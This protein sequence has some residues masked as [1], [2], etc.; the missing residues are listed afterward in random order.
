MEFNGN[1]VMLVRED[2]GALEIFL[3]LTKTRGKY[4]S[5]DKHYTALLPSIP[6][7]RIVWLSL[8]KHQSESN[9]WKG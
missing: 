7:M 4:L 6:K 9:S 1:E 3:C 8:G 2:H 5:P